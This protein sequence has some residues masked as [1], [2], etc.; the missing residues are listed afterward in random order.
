MGRARSEGT[1]VANRRNMGSPLPLPTKRRSLRVAI[2][3][4]VVIERATTRAHGQTANIGFG[5]AFIKTGE[6]FAYGERINL[7]IP[8]LGPGTVSRVSS[9]VRWCD[10][11]GFGVQF[12]VLGA[13]EA[14]ALTELVLAGA[15]RRTP[16]NSPNRRPRDDVPR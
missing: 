6:R 5:G 8:L 10:D 16:A 7:L 15:L 3:L 14:H 11:S 13:H 9:V 1:P 12:L 4:P 2:E